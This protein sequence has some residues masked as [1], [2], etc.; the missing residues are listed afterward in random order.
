M[1]GGSAKSDLIF[2]EDTSKTSEE[3]RVGQKKAKV[4]RCRSWTAPT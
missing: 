2:Q 3:W 4:I 1:V